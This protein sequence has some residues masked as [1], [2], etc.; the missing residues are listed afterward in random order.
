MHAEACRK[1]HA[2]KPVTMCLVE[3]YYGYI[4]SSHYAGKSRHLCLTTC[5]LVCQSRSQMFYSNFVFTMM[6]DVCSENNLTS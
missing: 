6:Y 3:Q 2:A 1:G 4:D 5:S